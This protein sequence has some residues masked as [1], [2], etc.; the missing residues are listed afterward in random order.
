MTMSHTAEKKA[1]AFVPNST[2]ISAAAAEIRREWS[3][4]ERLR[5]RSRAQTSQ[6]SLYGRLRST[7]SLAG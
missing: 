5:R 4:V 2:E 1:L 3:T 7:S 6:W